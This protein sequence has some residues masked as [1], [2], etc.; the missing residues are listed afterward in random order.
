MVNT[1]GTEKPCQR[2]WA[3]GKRWAL[4]VLAS[5]ALVL[6]TIA[7]LAQGNSRKPLTAN[8]RHCKRRFPGRGKKNREARRRCIERA[9]RDQRPPK[10]EGPPATS[11]PPSTPAEAPGP[12]E[13]PGS[14]PGLPDSAPDTVLDSA[15][16]GTVA[17][18]QAQFSFHS[19][20]LEST[21]QCNL[22]GA[23]WVTCTSPT[24]Y[25]GLTDG[26]HE[27]EVRAVDS[28]GTV[29]PTPAQAVWEIDTVA[30][31]TTITSAPSG[32]VPAGPVALSFT[33]SEA[34]GGFECRIDFAPF[35][36]CSS[37]FQIGAPAGE[38]IFEVR[39]FDHAGNRDQTP[40]QATWT[41]LADESGSSLEVIDSLHG[42]IAGLPYSDQVSASGGTAPYTFTIEDLPPGLN[43]D[44]EGRITGSPEEVGAVTL[45]VRVADALGDQAEGTVS[46]NVSGSLPPDC[47]QRSCSH[48]TPDGETVEIDGSS[49]VS[50]SRDPQS[51]AVDELTL[52][53]PAPRPQQII[54]VSRAVALP[55]GLIALV[56]T[57]TPGPEG[58]TKLTLDPASP[59][60][61]YADGTVQALGSPQALQE[62]SAARA[63]GAG[64]STGR[65]AAA[66]GSLQCDSGVSSE[67]HGL[68]VKPALTPSMAAIWHHPLF[69]GGGFYVGTG[70]LELFQFDLD[71][72]IEVNLGVTI[73]GSTTCTLQLPSFV[74]AVPAGDLGAILIEASPTITLKADG[75]VDARASVTLSCGT[76]YRWDEGREYR[77]SFCAENHQ[78][79]ALQA[80][81]GVDVSARGALQTTVSLDDLV[82][83]DGT[84]AATLHAGYT[85]TQ[86]PVAEIDAG[87]EY[88][89]GACLACFWK[90]APTRVSVAHGTVFHKTLATYDSQ[91][92]PPAPGAEG[93]IPV[94]SMAPLPPTASATRTFASPL[95]RFLVVFEDPS[96]EHA[97]LGYLTA[98]GAYPSQV[99]SLPTSVADVTFGPDGTAFATIG[100]LAPFEGG[101]LVKIPPD[102][103]GAE[104]IHSW[105]ITPTGAYRSPGSITYLG[106]RIYVEALAPNVYF[107]CQGQLSELTTSGEDIA[108]TGPPVDCGGDYAAANGQLSVWDAGWSDISWIDPVD[109]SVLTTRSSASGYLYSF[110]AGA[111][112]SYATATGEGAA[113][114]DLTIAHPSLGGIDYQAPLTSVL[115]LNPSDACGFGG[116]AETTA[117]DLVVAAADA[118]GLVL[119]TIHGTSI[120]RVQVGP[121]NAQ[122]IEVVA[123]GAGGVVVSYRLEEECEGPEGYPSKLCQRTVVLFR[124]G[125]TTTTIASLGGTY[126]E[127]VAEIRPPVLVDGQILL[128]LEVDT[129]YEGHER[130]QVIDAAVARQGWH[131]P[132]E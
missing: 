26:S 123:D 8:V 24:F 129:D 31:Q 94:G 11:A 125:G 117:G 2:D 55:S 114:S 78:P 88:E 112:G 10:T 71:G 52:S 127:G 21:F 124:K 50:V 77:Q 102:L 131:D 63:S 1:E 80:D 100:S 121:A 49:V 3:G 75:K 59:A 40:A 84:V 97:Y 37:P 54:V 76:E 113:C 12:P 68:D 7:G 86:H 58:T 29:D 48:L 41:S 13:A 106:G 28:V 33:N 47:M 128:S 42:A 34:G 6:A 95:N 23:D 30:P 32:E 60:D 5:V 81:S 70:G 4:I 99:L 25:T 82:G 16:Q 51:G 19:D 53:G 92:P 107:S 14:N 119:A 20:T 22:D 118:H 111:D 67:L 9:K 61:A 85:P 27:F 130:L 96:T 101:E 69:G 57:A 43:S 18:D 74:E 15:S 66:P 87:A 120:S 83:V 35:A 39:A 126:S 105:G 122:E 73:A 72:K 79:L 62:S 64:T 103:S 108:S 109:L 90:G 93:S 89:L 104:Q 98:G 116:V 44:P 45:Q 17:T 56:L 115:G 132:A 36:L 110:A 65:R 38:H 46:L 91:P